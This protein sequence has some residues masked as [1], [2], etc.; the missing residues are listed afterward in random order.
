VVRSGEGFLGVDGVRLLDL[1]VRATSGDTTLTGV[2]RGACFLFASRVRFAG[3]AGVD[4]PALP[5]SAD[6]SRVQRTPLSAFADGILMT[7]FGTTNLP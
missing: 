6:T 3:V 5:T 1:F 2:F 7:F 4:A